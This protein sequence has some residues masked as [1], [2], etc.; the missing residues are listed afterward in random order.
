MNNKASFFTTMRTLFLICV[1][2]HFIFFSASQE[3]K[4]SSTSS[5]SK[6][7]EALNICNVG[8]QAPADPLELGGSDFVSMRINH[9]GQTPFQQILSVNPEQETFL[10]DSF[11][12]H[13]NS[14]SQVQFVLGTDQTGSFYFIDFCLTP[15][16]SFFA[17]SRGRAP[18]ALWS[19]VDSSRSLKVDWIED[20][21]HVLDFKL[22]G[23]VVSGDQDYWLKKRI[24]LEGQI[25]CS[26]VSQ[27]FED[28]SESVVTPFEYFFTRSSFRGQLTLEIPTALQEGESLDSCV[29]RVSLKEQA[30]E[31]K[32]ES[33]DRLEFKA[34]LRLDPLR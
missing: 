21:N 34:F 6:S 23:F 10:Y 17:R 8:L 30:G 4:A 15:Q 27:S 7:Y 1:S 25:R 12:H 3:A 33:L 28:S 31:V 11:G 19:S 13:G 9:P 2:F 26:L 14:L 18:Q 29:V 22:E 20:L 32:R 5:S 24:L 16:K